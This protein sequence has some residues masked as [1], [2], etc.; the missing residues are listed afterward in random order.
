MIEFAVGLDFGLLERLENV[1]S[2]ANERRRG[3]A[4][5]RASWRS[6]LRPAW[7]VARAFRSMRA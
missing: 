4:D 2:P 3:N 5:L 7:S 6:A 1:K